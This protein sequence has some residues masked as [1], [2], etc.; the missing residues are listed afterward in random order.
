MSVGAWP[1]HTDG[2]ALLL[3]V[4]GDAP[5]PLQR[6]IGGKAQTL[7]LLAKRGLP[8]PRGF[9]LGTEAYAA[10]LRAHGLTEI[11][12]DLRSRLPDEEARAGLDE[13]L[14][15]RALPT[16]VRA[17]LERALASMFGERESPPLLAVRSSATG[18]DG[19]VHSFAGAHTSVLAVPCQADAIEDALRECWRSLWSPRAMTYRAQ[20]GIPPGEMAVLVQ[21]MIEPEISAVAFTKDPVTD[22]A[23]RILVTFAE[24]AGETL[25]AGGG[26]GITVT[27]DR[28][29]REVLSL[30]GARSVAHEHRLPAIRQ[31][32]TLALLIERL[33]GV[34]VDVEAVMSGHDRWTVVQARPVT[35]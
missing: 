13:L 8:V 7:D 18:E 15:G 19:T 4:G 5:T 25:M 31:L 35:T 21:E 1:N 33:L 27:L 10:T 30:D 12:L 24:G 14:V 23:D 28:I 3:P 20:F 22:G 2:Q 9:C 11:E 26:D 6:Q 16:E 32:G 17:E 29:T 34:A